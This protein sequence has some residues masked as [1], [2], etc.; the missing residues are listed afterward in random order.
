MVRVSRVKLVLRSELGLG[1][2][3]WNG[4]PYLKRWEER[5]W[6]GPYC[7]HSL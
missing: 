2:P 5:V 1:C 6:V 3:Y 4:H 7:I